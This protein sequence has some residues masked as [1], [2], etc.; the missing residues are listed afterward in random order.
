MSLESR[1]RK[2]IAAGTLVEPF[3]AK[4]L[5]ALASADP[6]FLGSEIQ[7]ESLAS[8]LANFSEG[9]GPRMGAS[10]KEGQRVPYIGIGKHAYRLKFPRDAGASGRTTA[11]TEQSGAGCR[12]SKNTSEESDA[13]RDAIAKD[14]VDYLREKPFRMMVTDRGGV[15]WHPARP[16]VGWK[17]RLYAYEWKNAGWTQTTRSI[18]KLISELAMLRKSRSVGAARLAYSHVAK[19]GGIEERGPQRL[20]GE[21]ILALLDPVW[22]GRKPTRVNSTL[23]KLYAFARPD[24]YVIYDSRVAAAIVT[25]AED[26]YRIRTLTRNGA[27]KSVDTVRER[28]RPFYRS[29]GTCGGRGGTRIRGYR[30]NCTKVH[31]RDDRWPNAYEDVDAQLEANDLCRRIRDHLNQCKEG[32]KTWNLREVEAVLFMEGY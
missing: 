12:Q 15:K 16:A 9:P 26:L 31:G 17:K 19:W 8:Y 6:S 23:T 25:I 10:V 13:S 3:T 22:N 14:F 11:E 30:I 5:R 27:Q 21:E 28:F 2:A 32:G 1:I 7:P 24:T 29:L 20:T 4:D 18:V